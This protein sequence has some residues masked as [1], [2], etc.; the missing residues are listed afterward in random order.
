MKWFIIFLV[1]TGIAFIPG[2]IS[3]VS[4]M[5]VLNEDWPDAPCMDMIVNGHYPQEQVDRWA[6]YH[7]YKGENFMEMKRQEMDKAVQSDTL[8]QWVDESI[9]N[10]NV[11]T[12]YYF[13]GKAPD[14]PNYHD[15]VFELI[16]MDSMPLQDLVSVNNPFWY[17]PQSWIITVIVGS[18][19]GIPLVIVWRKRK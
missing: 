11:W 3:D 4:S 10:Q 7:D 19:I 2:L 6:D 16:T 15:A 9:Q 5:C 18:V 8:Q 13:S 12:Y 17:D 14:I 1:L